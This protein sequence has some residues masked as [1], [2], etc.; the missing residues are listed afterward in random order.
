MLNFMKKILRFC[1]K[2]W[3]S[4]VL[5]NAFLPTGMIPY[6]VNKVY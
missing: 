3:H 6:S 1:N 2:T 5:N 4:A